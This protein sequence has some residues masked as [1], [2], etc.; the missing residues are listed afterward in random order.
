M[1][2]DNILSAEELE[3]YQRQIL[4]IGEKN[5]ILLKGKT[6]VQVGTG[7]LGGPLSLYLISAGIGHLVLFEDDVVSLSNLGRQILFRTEDLNKSKAEIT[8]LQL[9][10]LNPHVRITVI[11]KRLTQQIADEYFPQFRIDYL[12]DASD[13]FETKFLMNDLGI[14]YKIPFT[15]A[16]IQG[17]DGQILSVVP[18]ETACYRCIFG[19]PPPTKN[20]LPIPVISP[21]CGVLGSLEANEVIK[22]VLNLKGRLL[23]SLLMV[24][25]EI[26]DFSKIAISPNPMCHCQRK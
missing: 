14:Q 9:H 4:V 13:N 3:R 12:V 11:Q 5:Q 6:V 7:G 16:G 26:S 21:T 1:N 25:L 17:F 2:T 10:A 24:N 8:Y 19:E 23:N 15:I 18:H 22:G 20:K